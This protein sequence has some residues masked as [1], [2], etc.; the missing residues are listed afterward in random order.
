[1]LTTRVYYSY[2]D[3]TNTSINL[4]LSISS[5]LED[6]CFQSELFFLSFTLSFKYIFLFKLLGFSIVIT[7]FLFLF[8]LPFF[9]IFYLKHTHFCLTKS[10]T[11]A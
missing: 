1:M 9:F 11:S 3:V 4:L 10:V 5:F 2:P 8:V 7:F 6:I